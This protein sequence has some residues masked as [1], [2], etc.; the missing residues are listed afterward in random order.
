MGNQ[1][2]LGQK[3]EKTLQGRDPAGVA[4]VGYLPIAVLGEKAM[5]GSEVNVG[6][7]GDALAKKKREKLI[8]ISTVRGYAVFGKPPLGDQVL[9]EQ[10]MG[11][12]KLIW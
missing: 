3:T 5:D 10:L 8:Y 11:G 2:A 4:A 1:L 9:E 6:Q 7:V 12:V